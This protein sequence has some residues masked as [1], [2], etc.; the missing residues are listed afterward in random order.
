MLTPEQAQDLVDHFGSQKG[1]ARAIGVAPNTFVYWLDPET[2]KRRMARLY[3]ADPERKLAATREH[4]WTRDGIAHS[5]HLLQRRRSK[6]L[7]RR[8][9]R[10]QR[11]AS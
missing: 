6:A 4:Y 8:A 3:A 2:T 10:N 9:Q 5:R 1:A 7:K 11:R